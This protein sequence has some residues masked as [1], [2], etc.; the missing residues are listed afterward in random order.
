M[1]SVQTLHPALLSVISLHTYHLVTDA[2]LF[3]V[4]HLLVRLLADYSEGCFI[5]WAFL[6]LLCHRPPV[7]RLSSV[8][9]G[10]VFVLKAYTSVWFF[11][12]MANVKAGH[13]FLLAQMNTTGSSQI[14]AALKGY[15]ERNPSMSLPF[16]WMTGNDGRVEATCL[17]IRRTRTDPRVE[18]IAFP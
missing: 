9:E 1:I 8:L 2:A 10:T 3:T 14:T 7:L 13:L 4:I 11:Q 6:K 18:G 16:P 15:T 5:N 17:L 12:S